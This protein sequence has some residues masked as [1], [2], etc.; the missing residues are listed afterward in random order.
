MRSKYREVRYFCGEFLDAQ[1]FPVYKKTKSKRGRFQPTGECQARLNEKNSRRRLTRLVHANF[2]HRDL[3]LHLTYK[4]ECMPDSEEAAK[5]DLRNFFRRVRRLYKAA[6]V[7]FKYI[8]V[9]EKGSRSGRVHHHLIVTGGVSRDDLE[10]LWTA[11]RANTKRLQFDDNGLVGLSVYMTKQK[12]YFRRYNCSRN[13]KDPDK[14]KKVSDQRVSRKRAGL[15]CNFE[16]RESLE[17]LYPGYRLLGVEY[18]ISDLTGEYYAYVRLRNMGS[19]L[20][21]ERVQSPRRGKGF[22]GERKGKGAKRRFLQKNLREAD[23]DLTSV[24]E[25]KA[26]M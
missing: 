9:T 23:F 1:Y 8:S 6:G 17:K 2:C 22:V 4:D 24:C 25:V 21:S 7:E 11:G 13:L 5:K 26:N 3:A 20:Y 12:L 18:I 16:D 14:T 19:H 15:I 10:A